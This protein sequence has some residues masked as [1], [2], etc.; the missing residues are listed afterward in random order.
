MKKFPLII[1]IAL[2]ALLIRL[3]NAQFVFGY[4]LPY[5][6]DPFYHLRLAEVI[7]Y[8]GY[9]PD[10]DYYLNYP[11]GL[12]IDWLPLF[13]YLIAFPGILL[14]Y[15]AMLAF[16]F[17]LPVILGVISTVLIYY[18]ARKFA[19]NEAALLS[20]LIFAVCPIVVNYSV[21]GFADHHAW[22]LFLF[23][24]SILLI[25]TKPILASI[26][27]LLLSL[28]W[29]GAPIY[30]AVLAIA[31]LFHFRRDEIPKIAIAF[32][33]P[34]AVISLYPYIGISFLA[35]SAFLAL[36]YFAK[37]E[38]AKVLYIALCLVAV[39]IIYLLPFQQLWF[40]KSGIDYIFSRNV[41][42]PTIAEARSFEI[43]EILFDM[44]FFAFILAIISTLASN[45]FLQVLFLSAFALSL[46][47]IRFA[48]LLSIPVAVM[49]GRTYQMVMNPAKSEKEKKSRIKRR[50]DK[51]KNKVKSNEKRR[52]RD[53]L[54]I[55]AFAAFI[56]SPSLAVSI[57]SYTLSED[58]F[59]ALNWL[60]E[61]TPQ[62]SHYFSPQIKPE[63]SV[64]S[65]WDYGNWIVFV[66][67]RP[68][69]ANNFQAGA[70]DAAKFFVASDEEAAFEIAKKRGVRYIITDEKM[71]LKQNGGAISGKFPA[72]MS[73]A[74]YK[75]NNIRMGDLF[76]VYN[77]SIYYRLH[78]ENASNLTHFKLLKDFGSVKI[79]QVTN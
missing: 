42:L 40:F 67:K 39:L 45:R 53:R 17:I 73:I 6:Y 41:Y 22:N 51:K 71:G 66:S 57:Y 79:F 49:A 76:D 7:V 68:V 13:D 54:A 36:G 15:K 47:Q 9:R 58:W 74:G 34:A 50:E 35:I 24:L 37:N 62:T 2:I 18:I 63:Y 1:L 16:S 27:L 72:I 14:G 32:A 75:I 26:P 44:G 61:E 65:W 59:N 43:I 20:A 5:E 64:L 29:V 21:V 33:V 70:D 56:V 11:Y 28:S 10:F 77:K 78:V 12:R 23:I 60:R 31:S 25:L 30:A 38:K 55:A 4:M 69:V 48:E 3:Q 46:M 52:L 19:G 8:S